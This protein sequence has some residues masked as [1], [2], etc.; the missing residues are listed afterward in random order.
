MTDDEIDD[1]ARHM[2]SEAVLHRVQPGG[3]EWLNLLVRRYPEATLTDRE[4]IA[5]QAMQM[6]VDLR[7]RER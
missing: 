4:Y 3:N 5:M 6:I 7:Q 1:A 2:L